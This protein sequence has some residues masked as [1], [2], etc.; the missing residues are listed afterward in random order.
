MKPVKG[1]KG[2]DH[3]DTL[4]MPWWDRK[5]LKAHRSKVKQQNREGQTVRIIPTRQQF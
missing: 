3:D 5:L 4:G 1:V 2:E